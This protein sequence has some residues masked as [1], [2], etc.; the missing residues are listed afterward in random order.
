M[1]PKVASRQV[2]DW[3]TCR[4]SAVTLETFMKTILHRLQ[5]F[6]WRQKGN[7]SNHN[8]SIMNS[9]HLTNF[10]R[11]TY[12]AKQM[13]ISIFLPSQR[14]FLTVK[15]EILDWKAK[16]SSL[17]I[18]KETKKMANFCGLV[19]EVSVADFR[20]C[21]PFLRGFGQFSKKNLSC[22]VLYFWNSN[23]CE[24]TAGILKFL[25]DTK[26]KVKIVDFALHWRFNKC[27]SKKW[28][29]FYSYFGLYSVFCFCLIFPGKF[30][31][32]NWS[33]DANFTEYNRQWRHI[34]V[35]KQ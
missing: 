3:I 8:N 21:F 2:P 5:N 23:C 33:V 27:L 26:M 1:S 18:V 35:Y 11:G 10:W 6:F 15:K 4:F 7:L 29:I 32:V 28:L 19:F 20:R 24:R 30:S 22:R 9:F 17:S 14:V 16:R 12:F 25:D 34:S 31:K 13:S